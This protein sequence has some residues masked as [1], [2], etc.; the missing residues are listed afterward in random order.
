MTI[1]DF[2]DRHWFLALVAFVWWP[3]MFV[4]MFAAIVDSIA[5]ARDMMARIIRSFNGNAK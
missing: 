3:P 5:G 2:F 4:F 1:W